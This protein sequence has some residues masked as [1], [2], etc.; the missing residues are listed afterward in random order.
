LFKAARH[1]WQNGAATRADRGRG[2]APSTSPA[3]GAGQGARENAWGHVDGYVAS[4]SASGTK[5]DAPLIETPAAISVV[6]QD[7]IQAQGAQDINQALRYTSGV[8]GTND[9]DAR[10][11]EVYVRGFQADKYLD[12]LRVLNANIFARSLVDPFNLERVEVLHGPASVLYDQAS[13]G[14]LV[15]MISK[16]PTLDPQNEMFLSTGS[17]GRIQGG[18][19]SSGP[20]DKNKEW[21]YRITASGFDVGTQVDH[22]EYQRVSIAPS[23]TWRPTNDTTVTFLGTY[24][25]DPKAGFYNQLLPN[26]IGTMFPTPAGFIPT[27]FYDG[28]PGFDQTKREYGSIGY[29]FEHRLD[30]IWTIR[31][32][33]RYTDNSTYTQ[34][35]YPSIGQTDITN[36]AREAFSTAETLRSFQV[37]NQAQAKFATGPFQH[38]VLFGIDYANGTDTRRS[39]YAGVGVPSINAV[40][41]VYGLPLP[42]LAPTGGASQDFDQIG[43][44]VQAAR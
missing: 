33:L 35:V 18:I 24:Q 30:A 22:T 27:S 1:R 39:G 38:T 37:D 10:F 6:T 44:Y 25:N 21:L 31:Q 40:N 17:Y 19:D 5:T 23:L 16:R 43:G 7:Q 26:G 2:S 36:I 4:R 29:L 13:P 14:G 41:P 28:E 32:N 3:S 20:I 15:D 11:D 34:V 12:G 8:V 42:A 9:A